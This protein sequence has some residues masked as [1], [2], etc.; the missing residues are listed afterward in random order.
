[1]VLEAIKSNVL[2][3]D[4]LHDTLTD[5]GITESKDQ[6]VFVLN[7]NLEGI[8]YCLVHA[9]LLLQT[10][11]FPREDSGMF[12]PVLNQAKQCKY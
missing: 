7:L 2:K 10:N 8:L 6:L 3:T 5:D 9:A 11:L 12:F 1:M 4:C